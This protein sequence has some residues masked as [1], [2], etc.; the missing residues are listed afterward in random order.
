MDPSKYT[1][2]DTDFFQLE[3]SI[4]I[5]EDDSLGKYPYKTKF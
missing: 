4:K 5:R 3:G 2:K 1:L